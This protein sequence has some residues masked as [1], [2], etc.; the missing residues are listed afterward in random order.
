MRNNLSQNFKTSKNLSFLLVT[1][2]DTKREFFVGMD[3]VGFVRKKSTAFA[4]R[5]TIV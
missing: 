1:F 4:T 5:S 3:A 2:C